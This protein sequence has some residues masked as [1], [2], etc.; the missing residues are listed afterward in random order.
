MLK[1]ENSQRADCEVAA[2]K[3]MKHVRFGV[4]TAAVASNSSL[5]WHDT[6]PTVK[7][8]RMFRRSSTP[9]DSLTA[10]YQRQRQYDSNYLRVIWRH[11]ADKLVCFF[12]MRRFYGRIKHR[13]IRTST[14]T[15]VYFMVL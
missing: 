11:I 4:F 14:A 2:V 13:F 5:L 6:M 8:L 12:G 15:C 10:W 1:C 3:N 7:Y 9:T